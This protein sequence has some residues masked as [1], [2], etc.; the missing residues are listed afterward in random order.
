MLADARYHEAMVKFLQGR[1]KASYDRQVIKKG[2]GKEIDAWHGL[3]QH[4]SERRALFFLL[5]L[6][7]RDL[8]EKSAKRA[9]YL[10]AFTELWDDRP[11]R[12]IHSGQPSDE[13]YWR[14]AHEEMS[15]KLLPICFMAHHPGGG[16]TFY[17]PDIV[18]PT[19][20]YVRVRGYLS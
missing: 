15:S 5:N 6:Q 10:P 8:N 4:R 1:L 11:P 14:L 2:K 7:R 9:A 12:I 16:V 20:M 3:Y 13:V 18:P 19:W 17:Y